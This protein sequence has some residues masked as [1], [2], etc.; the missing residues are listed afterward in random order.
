MS[1]RLDPIPWEEQAAV[2]D[3]AGAVLEYVRHHDHVSFAELQGRLA[4]CT[5]T[6]GDVELQI[7]AEEY[8]T[9]IVWS[10]LAE[11][12]ARA[13]SKLRDEDLLV[14]V[15]CSELVY[16]VDGGVLTLPVAKRPPKGGYKEPHW[17]PV[18]LRPRENVEEGQ[19]VG[20]A[21]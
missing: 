2:G 19:F 8:G 6:R 7:V 15:P 18:V 12:L 14:Y 3:L 4:A 5:N 21:P 20:G 16:L 11:G 9:L 10:G 17:L 13:V 1:V